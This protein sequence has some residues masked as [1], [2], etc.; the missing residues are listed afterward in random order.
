MSY[1]TV[2]PDSWNKGGPGLMLC[3]AL[4]LTSCGPDTSTADALAR[5]VAD[6][7]YARYATCAPGEAVRPSW[8]AELSVLIHR[9]LLDAK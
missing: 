9:A 2:M 3:I 7:T 1:P 4:A 5:D 8:E 6:M